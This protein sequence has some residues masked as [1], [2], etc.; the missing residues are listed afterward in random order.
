MQ[1]YLEVGQIVNT[2]GL[3]GEL[4][5]KP[6]VDNLNR[7]EE[8]K[9]VYV[10]IRNNKEVAKITKVRYQKDLVIITLEDINT[11]EDAQKYKGA[12]IKINRKNAKSLE[13]DTYFIADLIGLEVFKE[14]GEF[15]GKIDDV[16]PTGS[17]DVYV[18]KKEGKQLLLPAISQVIKEVDIQNVKYHQ[19][20]NDAETNVSVRNDTK[21]NVDNN[22]LEYNLVVTEDIEKASFMQTYFNLLKDII[23]GSVKIK[24]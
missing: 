17:N 20:F 8:L 12:Y 10:E 18:V 22:T 24:I 7:F 19:L 13:E 2:V 16:F 6:F 14:E 23:T 1:E 5:V 4:K 15:L 9:E 21:L 3:K 11:I